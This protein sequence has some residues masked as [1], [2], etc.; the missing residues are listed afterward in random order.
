MMELKKNFIINVCYFSLIAILLLFSFKYLLPFLTPFILA[1]CL[2]YVLRG[3][4]FWLNKSFKIPYK[5]SAIITMSFFYLTAGLVIALISL[6]LVYGIQ[7]FLT[8][9]PGLYVT[10]A[11]KVIISI[12]GYIKDI[13]YFISHN[14]E[15]ASMIEN[16]GN[17]LISNVVDVIYK[18]S[19]SFFSWLSDVVISVPDFF[20]KSILMIISSFFIAVDYEKIIGFVDKQLGD[21]VS[22]LVSEI[23]S[24]LFGTVFVCVKSYAL[25]MSITFIELSIG[26]SLLGINNSIIIALLVSVL[27][28]L[29][30]LGT[31]AVIIPWAIISFV[32]GDIWIGIGLILVYLM[33]TIIRNIIEPR[34][35]GTQLGLHPLVTLISMFVGVNVAGI[36]GLFGFP[37]LLSLLV[38]LNNNGVISIFK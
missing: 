32:I 19:G 20:I 5:V 26:L 8:E 37:I 17:Q 22:K 24:Y 11:Q 14:E 21:K 27:D 30:V 28:I 16:G 29:P 12:T 2:V 4:I 35:V 3:V 23:K 33:I 34:I 9:L 13:I 18:V 31:G 10:Y 7:T 15:L 1:F 36:I 25:I 38:Y 6:C